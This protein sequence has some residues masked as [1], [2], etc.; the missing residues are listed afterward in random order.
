VY[1][2]DKN[3]NI[4]FDYSGEGGDN[5]LQTQVRKLLAE[6]GA[7]LP[8][9][10]D[11]SAFTFDPHQTPEIYAGYERGSFEQTLANPEGYVPNMVV[12][13]KPVSAATVSDAGPN[14]SFFLEGKWY[15]GGEFVRA[16]QDG[17]RVELPF[18]ARDVFIVAAP[19]GAKATVTVLLDGK[20]VPA[21][22]LGADAPGGTIDVNRDDLFR[23]LHLAGPQIHR[24]TLIVS[25]GFELYTFTFG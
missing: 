3:G 8:P 19:A 6:T 9:P 23:V 10:I 5:D 14:G 25:K 1:L 21:S 22:L 2:I 12:D 18:F 7:T 17:A 15:N 24:L 13:Y 20:A 4:A 11:F 16:Q